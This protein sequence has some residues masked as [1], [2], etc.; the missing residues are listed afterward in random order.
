D[1][2]DVP[3]W[4]PPPILG[5]TEF[6]GRGLIN[7]QNGFLRCVRCVGEV[8]PSGECLAGNLLRH[9]GERFDDGDYDID[10]GEC[11]SNLTGRNSL[12]EIYFPVGALDADT[13]VVRGPDAIIDTRALSPKKPVR[14]IY[15]LDT[16][17]RSGPFR[18]TA[19]LMFRSFP[20]YLVRAFADYEAKM[21]SR[22]R[23]PSGPLVSFDMLRRLERVE[24]ARRSLIVP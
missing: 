1:G 17:G 3:V 24:L 13:G 7:F 18:I 23:R 20:P 4:S 22:G 10:T 5:G 14:Y 8:S 19:K 11:R 2:P 12:F 9:R 15:E 16:Q 21:A 6:R